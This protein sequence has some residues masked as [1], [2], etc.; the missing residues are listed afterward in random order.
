VFSGY[1]TSPKWEIAIR[2][3][4]KIPNFEIKQL[5]QQIISKW[6]ENTI[7]VNS[8]LL[9]A[10]IDSLTHN[11]I[12]EFERHFTAVMGDTFS[13][14]D[15]DKPDGK[16]NREAENVWHAYTLGLLASTGDDYII[17]SNRESG[18]GR[19]DILMLPKDRTKYGV[20]FEIKALDKK[21]TQTAID[22]QLDKALDQIEKNEYYKE[23]IAHQI[24]KR[25]EIAVVFTGKKVFMKAKNQ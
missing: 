25:I 17:K 18:S 22:N 2:Q 1:L 24:P 15:I 7:K 10:M 8:S 9:I 16:R 19:Y 4:L 6:F 5:F 11:R 23:F 3:N 21:A 20:L 14:F 12:K 13:Y